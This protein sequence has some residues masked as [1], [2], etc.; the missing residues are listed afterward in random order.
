MKNMLMIFV[1]FCFS[2]GYERFV[3]N[4]F[5]EDIGGGKGKKKKEKVIVS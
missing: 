4:N 5:M 3:I 2:V 1:I